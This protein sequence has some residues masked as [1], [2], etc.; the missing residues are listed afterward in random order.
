MRRRTVTVLAAVLLG[1]SAL[2]LLRQP[3]TSRAPSSGAASTS[4]PSPEPPEPVAPSSPVDAVAELVLEAL[5][6]RNMTALAMHV[7]PVKGLRFSP[8][9]YVD[10]QRSVVLT[11]AELPRALNDPAARRWGTEDGSGD[12]IVQ[13]FANYYARFVYDRDFRSATQRRVNEF[14]SRSTTRPNIREVYPDATVVE[15]H[16]PGTKPESEGM[17]WSS[18]LLVFEQ[19]QSRWYLVALVHDQWTI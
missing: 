12:P 4:T 13:S 18:L 15:A 9:I 19:Y 10:P 14:G 7:H 6:Q 5:Q 11:A 17:D 1:M 8:Y 3:A 2:W 16:V